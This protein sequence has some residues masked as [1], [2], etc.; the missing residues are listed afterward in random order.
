MTLR[1]LGRH[2]EG[3]YVGAGLCAICGARYSMASLVK[4]A[5]GNFVCRG[6]GTLDCG[7]GRCEAEL[8]EAIAAQAQDASTEELEA[9]LAQY[10]RGDV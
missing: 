7:K 2:W 8:V 6:S 9:E 10:D 1:T 4:N 3:P 5:N